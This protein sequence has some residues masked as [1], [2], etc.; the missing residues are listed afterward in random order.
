MI[1]LAPM[2]RADFT[3]LSQII[4]SPQAMDHY[5]SQALLL[6]NPSILPFMAFVKRVLDD[7]CS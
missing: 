5:A 2:T 7:A 4:Q 1:N 3:P 6:K